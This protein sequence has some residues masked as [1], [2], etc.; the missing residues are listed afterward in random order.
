[1]AYGKRTRCQT[2]LESSLTDSAY[3]KRTGLTSKSANS[4]QASEI[5]RL[6][7]EKLRKVVGNNERSKRKEKQAKLED[8]GLNIT[9]IKRLDMPLKRETFKDRLSSNKAEGEQG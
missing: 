5:N 6:I 9:Q 3:I 2:E 4:E 8:F 1:L 7:I